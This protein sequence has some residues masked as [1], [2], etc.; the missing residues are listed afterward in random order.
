MTP[1]DARQQTLEAR[2][3]MIKS[4]P[5]V[6]AAIGNIEKAAKSGEY[7]IN[8]FDDEQLR[9]DLRRLG[10]DVSDCWKEAERYKS[11]MMTISWDEPRFPATDEVANILD[12]MLKNRKTSNAMAVAVLSNIGMEVTGYI[13]KNIHELESAHG[14]SNFNVFLR[15]LFGCKS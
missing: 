6:K 13:D 9:R 4:K 15:A 5:A 7:T 3:T 11:E 1:Q 8:V 2:I 10:W 14:F 12:S